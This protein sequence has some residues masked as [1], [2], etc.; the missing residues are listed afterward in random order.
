MELLGRDIGI[1]YLGLRV[2]LG[3][4]R[5]CDFKVI[6]FCRVWGFSVVVG[7][8]GSLNFRMVECLRKDRKDVLF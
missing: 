7:Y 2:E 6:F 4:F 8:L 5:I 1:W 3:A